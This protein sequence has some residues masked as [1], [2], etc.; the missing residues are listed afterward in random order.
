MAKKQAVVTKEDQEFLDS[1]KAQKKEPVVQEER[2]VIPTISIKGGVF[3]DGEKLK[4]DSIRIR[5][6]QFYTKFMRRSTSKKDNFKVVAETVS[7]PFK[8]MGKY[9]DTEGTEMLGRVAKKNIPSSWSEA[10]R[11]ENEEKGT[12]YGVLYAMLADD[13]RLVRLQVPGAKAMALNNFFR[14]LQSDTLFSN[15][16]D[17]EL[18]DEGYL[19]SKIVDMGLSVVPEIVDAL[20]VMQAQVDQQNN[21]VLS[22]YNYINKNSGTKTSP[23]D[24]DDSI[25]F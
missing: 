17:I 4:T 25:P 16:V 24:L 23:V 12:F 5:P 13:G 2:I 1:F 15:L 11:E 20:K 18:N 8:Q 10:Q 6:L 3:S 21:Y 19:V 9:F 14:D 7:V 22:R